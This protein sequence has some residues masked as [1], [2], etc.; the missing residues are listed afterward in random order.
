MIQ[1]T[2]GHIFKRGQTGGMCHANVGQTL[3]QKMVQ[4]RQYVVGTLG[5]LKKMFTDSEKALGP[6]GHGDELPGQQI[7]FSTRL[8]KPAA[9]DPMDPRGGSSFYGSEGRAGNIF[10]DELMKTLASMGG[11]SPHPPKNGGERATLGPVL[12]YPAQPFLG[13]HNGR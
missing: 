2:E 12:P 5:P 4:R 11:Q 6:M 10:E 7:S 8:G 13:G 9:D 1:N 3:A